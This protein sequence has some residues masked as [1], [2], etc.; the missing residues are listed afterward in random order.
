MTYHRP[1]VLMYDISSTSGNNVW[2]II[3][4]WYECMAY[5]DHDTYLHMAHHRPVVIMYDIS[6]TSG[7]NVWHIIDQWY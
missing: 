3:D 1:V 6:S 4:Q 5:Y 7:N 2:H